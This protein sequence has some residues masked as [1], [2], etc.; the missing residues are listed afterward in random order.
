LGD[1]VLNGLQPA[2]LSR[3]R[4]RREHVLAQ[5]HELEADDDADRALCRRVG[6]ELLGR[7]AC[8]EGRLVLSV[9]GDG[10]G[11]VDGRKAGANHQR[12]GQRGRRPEQ[13]TSEQAIPHSILAAPRSTI[14]APH[15]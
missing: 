10:I 5:H 6:N 14:G 11:G 15:T 3:D 2:N 1:A 8:R 12:R 13:C 7:S 4:K 9:D